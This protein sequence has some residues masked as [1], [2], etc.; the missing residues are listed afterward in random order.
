MTVTIP[1]TP[2]PRVHRRGGPPL[3]APALA[4]AAITV[5]ATALY[6]GLRPGAPSSTTLDVLRTH[7]TQATLAGV[8]LLASAAPLA[9]WTAAVHHRLGVLGIRVAGPTIALVGGL[10]AA[11]ALALSGLAGWATAA[12]APTA[13]PSTA[14]ALTVLAFGAGGPGFALALALLVTGV[15]VPVAVPAPGPAM[16]RDRRPGDRRPRRGGGAR[17]RGPG[18]RAAGAG[19]P[20]RWPAL[21]RRDQRGAARHPSSCGVVIVVVVGASGWVGSALVAHLAARGTPVR[22]L[23]RRPAS[24]AVPAGVE[25]VAADA[26]DPSSLDAAFAGVDRAF[27]MSA[28]PVRSDARPTHVAHLVEAARRAGVSRVVAL[29]VFGGGDGSDPIAA[30]HRAAESDVTGSGLGWT[31]LRPGRFLSNA[32]M[33]APM[34]RRGEVALPFA[35]RRAAGIDPSDVA[36]VAAAALDHPELDGATLPLTGREVLTPAEE[37]RVLGRVLSRAIT[38]VEMDDAEARRTMVAAGTDA[39]VVDAIVER[40]ARESAGAMVLPTVSTLLGRPP[41]NFEAWARAHRGLFAES[42][43]T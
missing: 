4:W 36:A 8:L 22:A 13:E 5:A 35:D 12:V 29:S 30:W 32:A 27:L 33:W 25:V 7:P 41:R 1:R 31:L 37:A 11:G 43:R 18:A 20:L 39:A 21:D 19:G 10:L 2:A 24:L 14:A 26:T 16:A 28:E 15:A 17:A 40:S 38:V 3:I 34:V 9:V 6:P 42:D 23:T